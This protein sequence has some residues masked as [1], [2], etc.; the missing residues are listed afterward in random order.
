VTD[1]VEHA[2]AVARRQRVDA[3][4]LDLS[5]CG[6]TTGLDFLVW[7]RHTPD[8]VSTPVTI[9]TGATMLRADQ[10][11]MMRRPHTRLMFKPVPYD[12][13]LA[14]VR[15]AADAAPAAGR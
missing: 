8:Y 10:M 11:S 6:G 12:E 1:S 13:L 2:I 5:L 4:T 7:L 9:L 3:I 15:G 14:S